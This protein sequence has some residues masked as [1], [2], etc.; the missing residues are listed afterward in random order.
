VTDPCETTKFIDE[1][2]RDM[3]ISLFSSDEINIELDFKLNNETNI[4]NV[5][6]GRTYTFTP[7]YAFLSLSGSYLR[8]F[9]SSP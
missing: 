6:G 9:S 5:C 2:F 4:Y 7:K 3:T 8:L 1:T